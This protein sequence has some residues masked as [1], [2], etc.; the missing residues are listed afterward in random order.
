MSVRAAI[1]RR[2]EN[3]W[4]PPTPISPDGRLA[5]LTTT[6]CVT[7]SA[8]VWLAVAFQITQ[9]TQD[10]P[11]DQGVAGLVAMV[12]APVLVAAAAL[13]WVVLGRPTDPDP[14]VGTRWVLGLSV[15][16]TLG[17]I[18]A[19][20]GIPSLACPAGTKLSFF[21][22]C[23]G[24]DGSRSP[25]AEY[26]WLRHIVDVVGVVIG[27]TVIRSR[28]WVHVTAPI[29]AAVWLAGTGALLARTLLGR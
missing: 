12:V 21:G 17:V 16:F 19:A 26:A 18:A 11:L 2:R 15:I 24:P 13:G 10:C 20:S 25:A 29:A 4:P 6:G 9:C 1:Q 14:G 28:R 22:F 7:L 8:A 3:R 5:G 23:A 27:F